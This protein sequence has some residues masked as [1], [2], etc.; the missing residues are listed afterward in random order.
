MNICSKSTI[1]HPG[2]SPE[3]AVPSPSPGRH[4]ATNSHRG[5]SSSSSPAADGFG[6][7]TPVPSPQSQSFFRGYGSILLTSLAYIFPSTKGCSPWRPDA[8]MSTTG[9][10]RNSVLQIFKGCRGRTGHHV[11]CGTLPTARPYLR[12]SH[13]QGILTRFPFEAHAKRAIRRAAPICIDGRSARANAPGFTATVAPSY[14]SRPSPCPDGRYRCGPPP[15]FPLASPC[16]GIVHHLS[17]PDRHALTRTLLRKSRSVGGAPVKDPANKFPY[18]LRVFCLLT[19]TYVRLLGP[20]FK[21]G[22]MGSPQADAL[23]TLMS[24]H[25]ETGRAGFHDQGDGISAGPWMKFTARLGLYSQ[26]TRLIDSASWCDRVLARQALT[27]YDA[28]FQGTW[29]RSIAED[30]SPDYNSDVEVPP[31]LGLRCEQR[32]C[33]AKRVIESRSTS[34]HDSERGCSRHYHRSSRCGQRCVTPRQMCPQPN[35]L[36]RNLRSKTRWFTGL[37]NSYQVSYFITFFVD[38]RAEISVAESHFYVFTIK[39]AYQCHTHTANGVETRHDH[40]FILISWHNSR[41][42]LFVLPRRHRVVPPNST[43]YMR[44]QSITCP[45]HKSISIHAYRSTTYTT[46]DWPRSEGNNERGHTITAWHEN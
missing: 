23:S 29:A 10:G 33:D 18:T 37:Y 13:F 43:K 36:G 44:E 19:R 20:C 38:A 21:T 3:E 35:G 32:K 6:T 8:V 27:L 45:L 11:T 30:T 31:D 42:G 14:S 34:A 39:Q 17:G 24:K 9:H 15:E 4:A 12:L 2:K 1:R 26:T 28:P 25:A 41:R 7:G 5:S 46:N 22:R 40:L 16:S